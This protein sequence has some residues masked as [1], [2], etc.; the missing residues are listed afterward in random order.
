MIYNG[1]RGSNYFL[2]YN[3]LSRS[4]HFFAYNGLR[5]SNYF[6]AYNGLSWCNHFFAYNGLSGSSSCALLTLN[7]LLVLMLT[8]NGGRCLLDTVHQHQTRRINPRV[9]TLN[10]NTVRETLTT[11]LLNDMANIIHPIGDFLTGKVGFGLRGDDDGIALL[12]L[13]IVG[14]NTLLLDVL[15]AFGVVTNHHIVCHAV[16]G[17]EQG[18]E[19]K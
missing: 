10:Q 1:L 5:G 15:V 9:D 6:L 13:V 19:Y 12:E 14:N 18:G 2:A 3:G 11:V 16:R 4:N 17:H 8:L 7:A